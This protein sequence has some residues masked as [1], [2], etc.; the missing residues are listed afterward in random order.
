LACFSIH[1]NPT[2]TES[3]PCSS[4]TYTSNRACNASTFAC[5]IATFA[6]HIATGTCHIATFACH[7]ET[8]RVTTRL[9]RSH[10]NW[11]CHDATF[12]VTS[13]LSRVTSKLVRVTSKLVRVTS[14]GWVGSRTVTSGMP[15][16]PKGP[17]SY[18]TLQRVYN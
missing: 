8:G 4:R 18:F 15:R 10:R 5:H 16:N 3:T 12:A 6:C 14:I 2:R 1:G 13:R 11:A 7:I 17:S 9:S